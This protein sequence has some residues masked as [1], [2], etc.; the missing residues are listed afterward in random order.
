M[1][2]TSGCI[3]AWLVLIGAWSLMP[4]SAVAWHANG[5]MIMTQIAYDDLTPAARQEV[6]RLIVVL[7]G[8]APERG[9]AVT[10]SLWAD[11]LR[12]QGLEA[13][14]GWHYVDL[15]YN[16][17]HLARVAP[18]RDENVVWAIGEATSALRGDAGDLPKAMMLRFLLHFVG[19]LHQPL[20]CASRFTAEHPEGDRGGND[21]PIRHQYQDLHAYWDHGA[22]AF[23]ELDVGDWPL[24]VRRHADELLRAVPRS[25]VPEWRVSEPEKW[26]QESHR[27]AV[28][29]VYDGIEEGAAPS[30]EYAARARQV[31]RR[32]LAL[33]GYRLGALLNEIFDDGEVETVI[34]SE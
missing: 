1:C 24:A 17:G 21:F 18:P 27:V 4:G 3:P 7:A 16:P 13:F 19:D 2:R 11:D 14:S 26:A 31:V 29:A 15:P 20:H 28:T 10:A 8:Y 6:D 30:A 5:H 33:G 9:H 25:A 32:R 22:G 12:H 34:A 23:P